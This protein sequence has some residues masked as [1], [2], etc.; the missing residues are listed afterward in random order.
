MYFY[1]ATVGEARWKDCLKEKDRRIGNNTTIEAF[2]LLVFVNNYKAWLYKEKRV[3]QAN[4]LTKYDCPPS[5]NKP[6]I[7]EKSW[8]ES[9]STL[10]MMRQPPP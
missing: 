4:L 1:T 3:H 8:M 7:V 5:S 10:I 6:S 9:S 2:A